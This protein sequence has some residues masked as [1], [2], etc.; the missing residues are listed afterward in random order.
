MN[1][2]GSVGDLVSLIQTIVKPRDG[3][4]IAWSLTE[5]GHSKSYQMNLCFDPLT[6]LLISKSYQSLLRLT[7]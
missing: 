4:N 7:V 1:K 2:R 5:L 6:V 3:P